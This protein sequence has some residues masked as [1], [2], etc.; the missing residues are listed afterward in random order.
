V[1]P[2]LPDAELLD[3]LA[4]LPRGR[5]ETLRRVYKLERASD[6]VNVDVVTQ[7]KRQLARALTLERRAQILAVLVNGGAHERQTAFRLSERRLREIHVRSIELR[8]T[9]AESDAEVQLARRNHLQRRHGARGQLIGADLILT[10]PVLA[11]QALEVGAQLADY[12]DL[13]DAGHE[14]AWNIIHGWSEASGVTEA[15]VDEARRAL[16]RHVRATDQGVP[17][18]ADRLPDVMPAGDDGAPRQQDGENGTS[19][20]NDRAT[21][22]NGDSPARPRQDAPPLPPLDLEGIDI[23][24]VHESSPDDAIEPDDEGS[25]SRFGRVGSGGGRVDIVELRSEQMLWGNRGEQWVFETE[26][27]RM[28]VLGFPAEALIWRSKEEPTSPYDIESLDDN[29]NRIYIEVKST[30]ASDPTAPCPISRAELL[31]AFDHRDEYWIYRV[32]DVRNARPVITPYRNPVGELAA[33]HAVLSVKD[34]YLRL[35]AF[36]HEVHDSSA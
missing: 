25:G 22:S 2:D 21:K 34:A 19:A 28:R 26:R 35:P 32:T 16:R 24:A 30:T 11:D 3:D 10:E 9:V 7:G 33:G 23:P 36:R 4:V 1:L 13:P 15:D 17:E 6:V 31:F 5:W 20:G 27:K 29:G 12:L 14:I 8:M 18:L